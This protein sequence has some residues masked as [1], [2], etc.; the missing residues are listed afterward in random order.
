MANGRAKCGR[1]RAGEPA[2]VAAAPQCRSRLPE[3]AASL[4]SRD[5]VR[6]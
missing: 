1:A 6:C 5:I 4:Q 3:A 2:S